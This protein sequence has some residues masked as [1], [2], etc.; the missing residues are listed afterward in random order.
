MQGPPDRGG[1]A[2]R[3]RCWASVVAGPS[4]R[5]RRRWT[6]GKRRA[7]HVREKKRRAGR[8][9]AGELEKKERG[10]EWAC[11]RKGRPKGKKGG[12]PGCLGWDPGWLFYL[13]PIPFLIL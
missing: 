6:A 9:E 5:W 11:A 13:L 3:G 7:G 2:A 12:R 10:R 8:G 1:G 4:A